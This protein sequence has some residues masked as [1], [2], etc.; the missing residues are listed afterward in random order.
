MVENSG[1]A[2][3]RGSDYLWLCLAASAVTFVGF[4]FTYFSP[5]LGGQYPEVSPTVHL[6][7]WTFFFWYLLLPLQAG[8]VKSRR[9]ALHRKLGYGSIGLAMAMTVTGLVVIGVQMELARQPEGSPFWGAL[10]PGV[11][12]TLVL[13]AGFYSLAIRFRRQRE[14]HKRFVLLASAGGLGAAG[15]RIVAQ[16]LGPGFAAGV[17]GILLP[18]LIIVAAM[19]L[20]LRRDDRIHAVYSWGLPISIAAE[21]GVILMTPHLPGEVLISSLAWM[22]RLLG[23]LY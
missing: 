6:H 18:N 5:M 7:G 12:V 4:W 22:G 21:A 19:V 14:L 23:P 13:F 2:R 10:G 20:E 15:F 8:L 16:I 3:R 1:P 17:I 9:V 11:F